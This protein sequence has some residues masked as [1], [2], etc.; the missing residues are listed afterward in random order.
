MRTLAVIS[1]CLACSTLAAALVKE[2]EEPRRADLRIGT[3]QGAS[4]V[5]SSFQVR[6]AWASKSDLAAIVGPTDVASSFFV[7]A[8]ADAE[9]KSLQIATSSSDV[10]T[11]KVVL[12]HHRHSRR[13]VRHESILLKRGKT[14]KLVVEYQCYTA[15]DVN[16]LLSLDFA[17][18]GLGLLH[19]PWQKSCA[20]R[21]VDD[22]VLVLADPVAGAP[23]PDVVV[24]RGLA[25]WTSAHMVQPTVP[26]SNFTLTLDP[27]AGHRRAQLGMPKVWTAGACAAMPDLG[28]AHSRSLHLTEGGVQPQA[29][30][31]VFY[32]CA[33]RGRCTVGVEIPLHSDEA[34]YH[35]VRWQWTKKC[36][37][38]ANG[39]DV[40]V[41]ETSPPPLGGAL[42]STGMVHQLLVNGQQAS[43]DEQWRAPPGLVKHSVKLINRANL[44]L[45]D[46]VPVTGLGVRCLSSRHCSASLI[47]E[48]PP[49][50]SAVRPSSVDIEYGCMMSGSSLVEL[51]LQLE[52]RDTVKLLWVKDCGSWMD[53]WLGVLLVLVLLNA[54][55]LLIVGMSA[56]VKRSG[57]TSDDCEMP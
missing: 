18:Q 35:P 31:S 10:A 47:S 30:F 28:A 48:V 13:L 11:A 16:V 20:R 52:S 8:G 12:G 45:Q 37:G 14:L 57:S 25:R 43:D 53:S 24:E 56:L 50:L 2:H 9:L 54:T 15:G 39:V 1:V 33:W 7:V 22:A 29:Q 19:I 36:D 46:A 42:M 34:L 6:P 49:S 21:L 51:S 32:S 5:V 38:T 26:C 44:S 40:E 23:K 27:L 41:E 4:N 17:T 55:L 3:W